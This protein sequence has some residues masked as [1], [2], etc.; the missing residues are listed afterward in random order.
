MNDHGQSH[1]H[2]DSLKHSLENSSGQALDDFFDG[3]VYSP[4]FP[5]FSVDSFS[6]VPSGGMFDVTVHVRQRMRGRTTLTSNNLLEIGFMD[7][8][9]NYEVH[10][11]TFSAATSS[12]TYTMPFAPTVVMADPDEKLADATT[13]YAAKVAGTAAVTFPQT[14][15]DITPI[16]APDSA[17]YRVTHNWVAPDPFKAVVN[18]VRLAD[19]RHWLIEGIVPSGWLAKATLTYDGRTGTSSS[20]TSCFL[21]NTWLTSTE[22]SLVLFYRA[23]RA[24]DWH[25]VN[26]FTVN[27]AGPITDKKGTITVDTL[28]LGEYALGIYDY[29]VVSNDP[30]QGGAFPTLTLAPNPANTK[31]VLHLN[32]EVG[33][34]ATLMDLGGRVLSQHTIPSGQRQHTLHT[35][36]L[37]E[38]VYLLHC[39]M[40][41]GE[42]LYHR[43]VIQR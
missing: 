2:S 1:A 29:T 40:T 24:D 34:T 37:A 33:A 11:V 10:P 23:D 8:A 9:G 21:D 30:A 26:G 39:Q 17:W 20:C 35:S 27:Y 25:L 42:N 32:S 13:D 12:A 5:H 19:S 18:G 22:D 38:G 36:E 15:L 28:K 6:V 4:G 43:L 7:A 3:W 14:F 31:V 41:T 16:S